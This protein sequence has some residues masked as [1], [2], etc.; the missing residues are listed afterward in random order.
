MLGFFLPLDNVIQFLDKQANS[1]ASTFDLQRY[2]SPNGPKSW[3][4]ILKSDLGCWR[5]GQ[6]FGN[7]PTLKMHL[8]DEWMRLKSAAASTRKTANPR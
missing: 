3:E 5:C 2:R 6:V 1:N 4:A 8:E 7:M